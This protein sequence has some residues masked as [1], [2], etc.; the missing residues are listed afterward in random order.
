MRILKVGQTFRLGECYCRVTNTGINKY[1]LTTD[2]LHSNTQIYGQ[3]GIEK[4]ELKDNFTLGNGLFPECESLEELTEVVKYILKIAFK[5]TKW[6]LTPN[7]SEKM[8]ELFFMCGYTWNTPLHILETHRPFTYLF[9]NQGLSYCG[10]PITYS[11]CDETEKDP[12]DFL[13]LHKL[14]IGQKGKKQKK[15]T[16]EEVEKLFDSFTE[17]FKNSLK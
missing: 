7:E 1:F 14:L 12:K 8:Q 13:D 9:V 11:T 10:L 2:S 3:F 16:K 5:H 17:Q 6:H 15:Y 4:K